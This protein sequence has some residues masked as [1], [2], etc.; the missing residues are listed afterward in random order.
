MKTLRG[1]G[2]L[3]LIW[4]AITIGLACGAAILVQ[5]DPVHV[6]HVRGST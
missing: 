3:V 6:V 5:V 4:I 2:E 1:I